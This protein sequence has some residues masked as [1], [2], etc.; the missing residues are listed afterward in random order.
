[1]TPGTV[2]VSLRAPVPADA[3]ARASLGISAVINRM[4][5][6][7]SDTPDVMTGDH[8]QRWPGALAPG[9]VGSA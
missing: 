8:A 6:F 4:Q 9:G 3:E 2:H 7:A 5:G 1:M